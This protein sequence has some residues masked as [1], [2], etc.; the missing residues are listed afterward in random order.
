MN[1]FVL[2]ENPIL[3]GKMY[4]DKH[5]PKM[6]VELYQQLGSAVIR[7]G[8]TP[9]QLPLTKAGTPLRGGYHN[10]PA[11]RWVGDS[12]ANFLWASYHAAVLC[13]EYNK[14]FAKEHFCELGLEQLYTL[15][16][17]IPE[18]DLTPFAL[19]MPDEYRPENVD[20]DEVIYHATGDV[21]V[22]AYRDYYHSKTFAR[23]DKGRDAPAW[24]KGAR[25]E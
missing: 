18:G 14:R 22:Q 17:L 20:G 12:R 10:H 24:W 7:H 21:A 13:E 8:A 23:W 25:E 3:A 4:C 16:Y 11:T 2:D 6:V 1:I 5:V 9:D 19:C 15:S